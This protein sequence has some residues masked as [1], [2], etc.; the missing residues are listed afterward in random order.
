[1]RPGTTLWSFGTVYEGCRCTCMAR[2]SPYK[3]AAKRIRKQMKKRVETALE[4]VSK[5]PMTDSEV[6]KA[7]QALKKAR[8]SLRLLR[9]AL[10]ASAYRRENTRLRDAARPLSATRDAHVV[11]DTLRL[12]AH[13][14]GRPVSALGVKLKQDCSRVEPKDL[15]HSRRLL[16]E[17]RSR[18]QDLDLEDDNWKVVGPALR[19]V[20][21][22]GRR[23]LAD[24]RDQPTPEAFHEWRK[25]AKYLRYALETLEP[26]WPPLMESLAHE[27]H[28]LTNCLGNEH[29]LTVL[30]EQTGGAE[31]LAALISRFQHELRQQALNL[32]AKLY[33]EKP[34]VFTQ[35]FAQYWKD[36][37][38][39]RRPGRSASATPRSARPLP[40]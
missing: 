27:A 26:I 18:L 10:S 36:W 11:P 20:Y 3:S 28:E 5:E 9:P 16:R 13:H 17:A 32:G 1:M 30:R 4:I 15:A 12:V 23:A 34:K 21:R 40:P 39:P 19:Q 33:E 8:A 24:A 6:H 22:A 14:C 35:R 25:Q 38:H 29:D 2:L 37:R 7:R 31:P